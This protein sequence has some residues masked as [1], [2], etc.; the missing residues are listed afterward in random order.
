MFRA[1]SNITLFIAVFMSFAIFLSICLS[2]IEKVIVLVIQGLVCFNESLARNYREL[3]HR[4][5][6]ESPIMNSDFSL[7][8][9]SRVRAC[10]SKNCLDSGC[11]LLRPEWT[12]REEF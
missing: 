6:Q 1:D 11:A 12:R 3:L 7:K 8:F 2:I 10:E 5:I 4:L 9:L